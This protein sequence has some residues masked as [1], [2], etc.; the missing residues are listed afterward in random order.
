MRFFLIVYGINIFQT[1]FP[2]CHAQS[3]IVKKYPSIYG[4][5]VEAEHNLNSKKI[6]VYLKSILI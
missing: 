3:Q 5:F 2:E 1:L 6:S 4:I